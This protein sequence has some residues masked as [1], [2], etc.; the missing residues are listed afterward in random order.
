MMTAKKKAAAVFVDL[1]AAYDTVWHR[2]LTCKLLRLLPDR[3]M[4]KMIMELVS[5]RSF[6]PLNGSK[7]QSMLR[8]LKKKTVAQREKFKLC[9]YL[10]SI[11][12]TCSYDIQE[13]CIC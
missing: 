9:S 1:T 6:T 7:K 5:N 3:H 13:I 8:H 10:S 4:V 2:V 12:M 11:S